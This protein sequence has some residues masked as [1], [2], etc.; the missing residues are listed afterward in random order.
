MVAVLAL[1]KIICHEP[2][3]QC[4]QER[5]VRVKH[6]ASWLKWGETKNEKERK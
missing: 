2:M 1:T 4:V 3:E 6:D 5:S